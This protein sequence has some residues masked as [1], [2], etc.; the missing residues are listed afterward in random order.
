[1]SA[2]AAHSPAGSRWFKDRHATGAVALAFA[3]AL[4][5]V[6]PLL[7]I[8]GSLFQL[9]T[10]VWAHL[11]RYV[12]PEVALNTVK[13]LAGVA[14]LTGIIGTAL[15][16]LTAVC[17]FPGRR[18]FDWA[19]LLPLSIP[20]YVL[21]FVAVGFLDY[22]G[23][24][25][26]AMR[27]AGLATKWLP[28]IRSSNG[29]GVI[30]VLSLALYPYVYLLARSAF[31]SQGRRVLEA[32]QTLGLT[33]RA[34]AWRVALPM[35]RPWIAAG[36][37]LVAMETLADF[38]TVSVFNYNTFTKAIYSAW[39]GMFSVSAALELAAFLMLFVLAALW[40]ER[41]SRSRV[42][43]GGGR[44]GAYA[45]RR[46]ELQ[47]KARWL[48]FAA[49]SL[50]FL[51]AFLLPF[52]QL[53]IWAIKHAAS[54]LDVRYFGFAVRSLLLAGSAAAV[55]LAASVVLA[56]VTRVQSGPWTNLFARLG[57]LGY[58]VPGTVLA[59]GIFVPMAWFNNELQGWLIAAFGDGA[60]RVYLQGSLVTV[61]VA[62]MARFLAVGF[63]P[64]D[65]SLQRITR[66]IDEAAISLGVT[67][68][69]MLKRV[70][71]PLLR[72]GI[73][74]GAVLVF[75]DVMKEMPITLITRP[76]GWDTLAVRVFEMTTEGE[77]ERAALPAV[78]IVLAGLVPI[79]LLT[80]RGTHV[81]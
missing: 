70:H 11:S 22:S 30:V 76:F 43:Y 38:G 36:I 12:L 41:R 61:L 60:P 8:A 29:W 77:W 67:G 78:V 81:A 1:M 39:F 37:S 65:S 5:A 26:S 17:N 80:R 44:S 28:A 55:I 14:V 33:A 79:A 20:G 19:L 59:V 75:V 53:L 64:V 46:I 58:A 73:A 25:Q 57:T 45:E 63:G 32:A 2:V 23:P 66:N 16:W 24:L 50:V 54:D 4:P 6:V 15:A 13:L 71:L 3:L 7:V 10:E 40:L 68:V 62:Y 51:L 35:A 34:A 27:A 21:A 48:A 49:A 42:R 74:T 69:A 56:Y 31:M 47:G 9:D 52:L 18:F 72:T